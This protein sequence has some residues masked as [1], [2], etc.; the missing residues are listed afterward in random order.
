M[1]ESSNNILLNH[2]DSILILTNSYFFWEN[3][4]SK[5]CKTTSTFFRYWIFL[6]ENR[7]SEN[8][9]P[10]R[11]EL[12]KPRILKPRLSISILFLT[13][14]FFELLF[15]YFHCNCF[16]W[17]TKISIFLFSANTRVL[18]SFTIKL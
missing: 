3:W 6:S 7:I 17:N 10:G 11:K 4:F 5:I 8:I 16:H 9:F 18:F 1:S 2:I 15:M 13:I 14:F 12:F